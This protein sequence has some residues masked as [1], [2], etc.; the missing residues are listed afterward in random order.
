MDYNELMAKIASQAKMLVDDGFITPDTTY[1]QT[2]Q[3]FKLFVTSEPVNEIFIDKF[4]MM[5]YHYTTNKK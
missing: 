2:L 3:Y 5:C 1:K 4:F